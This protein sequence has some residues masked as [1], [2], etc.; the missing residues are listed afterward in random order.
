MDR[1]KYLKKTRDELHREF[2]LLF[3]IAVGEDFTDEPDENTLFPQ[4]MYID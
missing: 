3:I 2:Y 1:R 4:F